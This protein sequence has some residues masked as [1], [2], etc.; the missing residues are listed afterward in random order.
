MNQLWA[1]FIGITLSVAGNTAVLAQNSFEELTGIAQ[2]VELDWRNPDF[3]F[4]FKLPAAPGPASLVIKASPMVETPS[5]GTHFLLSINHKPAL[6]FSPIVRGFS[7]RF[8]IPADQL[9]PGSNAIQLSLVP[10]ASQTCLSQQDGGWLLDLDHSRIDL[11][12]GSPKPALSEF[13]TWLAADIGAPHKVTIRQGDLSDREYAEFGA[14]IVQALALRMQ[15]I[16]QIVPA[17]DTADLIITGR[18]AP[19]SDAG[20]TLETARTKPLLTLSGQHAFQVLETARWFAQNQVPSSMVHGPIADWPHRALPQ[21]N[22]LWELL[23]NIS[24]PA[25][26]PENRPVALRLPRAARARLLI[27]VRRPGQADRRSKLNIFVDG[28]Q[29]ASPSLWRRANSLSVQLPASQSNVR[30]IALVPALQPNHKTGNCPPVTSL[31]QAGRDKLSLQ[32]AGISDLSDLDH[33][34]WNG[35]VLTKDQG[36]HTQIL[37]PKNTGIALPESWRFLGKLAQI[38]GSAMVSATYNPTQLR[39]DQH[40]LA[41][42]ERQD[43]PKALTR[44]LPKSFSEGAGR[45][46]GDPYPKYPRPRL[47]QSAFAAEPN[48]PS[49]GIAGSVHLPNGRV[50]LGLSANGDTAFAAALADLVDGQA[51]DRFGGTVVRWRQNKVEINATRPQ[52]LLPGQQD[53]MALWKMIL[54]ILIPTGLWSVIMLWKQKQ[55]N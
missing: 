21:I 17:E 41:L 25:W 2:P 50:W 9:R 45:A 34:A 35:G 38:S 44:Q 37:L 13:E 16:P 19:N 52:L 23:Q 49:V 39:D 55:A 54:L 3:G 46:P 43:L 10:S 47:V 40:L 33:L 27:D 48:A 7:A 1:I 5:P 20:F 14:L 18:I 30:K 53:P 15:V 4:T 11:A 42:T 29:I 31:H 8:D 22:P 51:F 12:L 24:E 28:Q 36:Q 6:P 26:S 32:L